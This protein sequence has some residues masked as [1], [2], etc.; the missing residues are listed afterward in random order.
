MPSLQLSQSYRSNLIAFAAVIA[1]GIAFSN[2]RMMESATAQA[3]DIGSRENANAKRKT[4]IPWI[5]RNRAST[6][7]NLSIGK[8]VKG[9][10]SAEDSASDG[11]LRER[12]AK[13]A[14]AVQSSTMKRIKELDIIIITGNDQSDVDTVKDVFRRYRLSHDNIPS[15][16]D[17]KQFVE[18]QVRELGNAGNQSSG[19]DMDA[20]LATVWQLVNDS[21]RELNEIDR[22]LDSLSR[23][24]IEHDRDKNST[25]VRGDN[26]KDTERVMTCLLRLRNVLKSEHRSYLDNGKKLKKLLLAERRA[27]LKIKRWQPF[28]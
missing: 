22:D 20:E 18:E 4:G 13:Q 17:L 28:L 27:R 3:Q 5:P 25:T 24:E 26:A 6:V 1:F 9:N 21:P 8:P 10:Q 23:V 7:I 14:K 11:K 12:L 19:I 15:H 2:G 16:E